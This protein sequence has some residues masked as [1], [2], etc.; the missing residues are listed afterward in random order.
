MASV[1]PYEKQEQHQKKDKH[2][3]NI[4][5]FKVRYFKEI[6]TVFVYILGIFVTFLHS[7]RK[8][9]CRGD[10]LHLTQRPHVTTDTHFILDLKE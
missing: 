7:L 2:L 8:D 6:Y 4:L 10:I 5:D 9:T 3:G 1:I